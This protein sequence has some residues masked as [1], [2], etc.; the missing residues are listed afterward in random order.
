MFMHKAHCSCSSCNYKF[1]LPLSCRAYSEQSFITLQPSN[2]H[3]E[4]LSSI[5]IQPTC[6]RNTKIL[7]S[8]IN[9]NNIS[10]LI[11]TKKKKKKNLVKNP[12]QP[13]RI[14]F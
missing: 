1:D 12:Y 2:C 9:F 3:L 13:D 4:L 14:E 6:P 5:G 10:G 7:L 8:K 11:K